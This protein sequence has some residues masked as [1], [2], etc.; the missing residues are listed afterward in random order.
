MAT[1]NALRSELQNR[2]NDSVAAVWSTSELDGYLDQ[3]IQ[4]LYP[5]WHTLQTGTTVAGAGPIQTMPAAAQDLYYVGVQTPTSNRVRVMRGWQEGSGS[6]V[7]P[8]VG[9]TGYTLVWAWTAPYGKPSTGTETLSIPVELEEIVVQR[10]QITA[11]ERVLSDRTKKAKYFAVNVREGVT[12]N[13]IGLALDALHAS[14]DSRA[15]NAMPRPERV[16]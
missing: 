10:A 13:E 7:I 5:T 14:V 16:G 15:R 8:K 11:L 9:I 1:R 12:E 2:L 6:A 3:S 4:S